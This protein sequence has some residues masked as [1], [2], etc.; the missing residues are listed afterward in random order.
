MLHTHETIMATRAQKQLPNYSY[1][2]SISDNITR[3][4][5]WDTEIAS[6]PTDDSDLLD[7][8]F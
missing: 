5:D 8:P 4:L 2:V 6:Y 1:I 3:V 7:L